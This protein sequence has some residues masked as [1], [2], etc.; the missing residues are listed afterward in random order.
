MSAPECS[1]HDIVGDGCVE[2]V[3]GEHAAYDDGCGEEEAGD[4]DSAQ[5]R[6]HHVQAEQ[7]SSTGLGLARLGVEV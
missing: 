4:V 2:Q 6:G 3:A 5:L 1:I 7:V